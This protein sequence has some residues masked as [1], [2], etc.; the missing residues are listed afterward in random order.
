MN[1]V[2]LG[3]Y[4]T[5]TIG[6]RGILLGLLKAFDQAY[7]R[8]S[9][10]LGSFYPF[11]SERTLE[12]D[13]PLATRLIGKEPDISLFHSRSPAALLKAIA[14]ADMVVIGGG[15]MMH[16]DPLFMFEFAI[17]AARRM[18]K[19]T[20]L[21]ACGV[22]PLATAPM[23]RSFVRMAAACDLVLLRDTHS[24]KQCRA[25]FEQASIP[26]PQNL[27]V[28]CDPAVFCTMDAPAV[29]RG[30]YTVINLRDF[31]APYATSGLC[32]KVNSRLADMV[33][34]LAERLGTIILAPMNH[35]HVGTDDR[36]FLYDVASGVPS[37]NVNV[38][39]EILSLEGT[40]ELFA[41]ARRCIGMRFHS[42]LLQTLLNGNNYI[43]DYT[44][45][46]WGKIAGFVNDIDE[47]G[48][49]RERYVALQDDKPWDMTL[50]ES[51]ERFV[52]PENWCQ[53]R[54]ALT[55]KHLK[56]IAG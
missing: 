24:E 41:S 4:G 5:E 16:F 36:Y 38:T 25:L 55:V 44:D 11:Y 6:D 23:Q 31:P 15:P 17:R 14:R 12:E 50:S 35:F 32:E 26:A 52:P 2:I 33:H 20:A 30:D 3:W 8:T 9:I 34:T 48:F 27:Q 47:H 53:E 10:R 39:S 56:S 29:E 49:Y 19:R 28:G 13:L 51:E 54:F 7:G 40:M 21:A 18:G 43:L 1:I 45:P 22:G 46:R 42:V 37:G